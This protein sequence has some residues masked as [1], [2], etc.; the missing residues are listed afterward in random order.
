MMNNHVLPLTQKTFNAP[1]QSTN[2]EKWLQNK[3]QKG[4]LPNLSAGPLVIQAMP[5]AIAHPPRRA[6]GF[7]ATD[8]SLGK[9]GKNIIFL[10]GLYGCFQK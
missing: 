6:A 8:Q 7:H 4:Y 3:L 1:F 2:S 5:V 10:V 9:I